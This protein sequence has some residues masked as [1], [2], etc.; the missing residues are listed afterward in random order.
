M[1]WDRRAQ[2]RQLGPRESLVVPPSRL[3]F[4][5][6]SCPA[7][8]RLAR[9][10]SHPCSRSPSIGSSLR[11]P[12]VHVAGSAACSAIPRR[13]SLVRL[14]KAPLAGMRRLEGHPHG[15]PR[16]S[17]W[18]RPVGTAL[19]RSHAILSSPFN[20]SVSA[21]STIIVLKAPSRPRHV[22]PPLPPASSSADAVSCCHRSVGDHRGC[23]RQIAIGP[24]RRRQLAV[25]PRKRTLARLALLTTPPSAGGDLPS[26]I[27]CSSYLPSAFLVCSWAFTPALP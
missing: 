14:G 25:I 24:S 12:R 20:S 9:Y 13:P 2:C 8:L 5:V 6:L 1:R 7:L 26:G 22:P 15:L 18:P 27:I 16:P 11:A 23:A 19:L 3:P 21:T 10:P 17:R 4:P